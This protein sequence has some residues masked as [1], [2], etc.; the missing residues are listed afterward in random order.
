MGPYRAPATERLGNGPFAYE[1]DSWTFA[2][3]FK[4][5]LEKGRTDALRRKHR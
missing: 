2:H 3:V 1:A 5:A 4:R